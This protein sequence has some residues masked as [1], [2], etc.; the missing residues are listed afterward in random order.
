MMR[1]R[2]AAL[3]IAALMLGPAAFEAAAQSRAKPRPAPAG[4]PRSRAVTVGGYA[5]LGRINFTAADSFDAILGEHAGPIFGGGARIGLPYGGLFV[6]VGAWRFHGEGER[7]IVSGG[8]TFP[9][10]IDTAITIVP[11]E[12][13]AGWQFR[14]RRLPKLLPFVA[15]GLT[16]YG[17]K[18]T[19]EFAAGTEE[20][21]ERF[22]GY[23]LSGGAAYRV[24][25]WL[26]IGGEVAWTTVPDAIGEG[27][28]SDVFNE[29]NLGGTS[30][31]LKVTIGR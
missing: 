11:V 7:V 3:A 30:V 8:Q 2:A 4:A 10:G 6:D 14:I 13:S 12:I 19:S 28:V 5:M 15:G 29:D 16:S 22:N 31:R 18:E 24:A 26:G 20:V 9:L 23:H 27:G 21:D 17:Y 1:H 25:R